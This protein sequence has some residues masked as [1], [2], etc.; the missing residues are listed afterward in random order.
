MYMAR[1]FL[2]SRTRLL[3]ALTR[4][5]HEDDESPAEDS[6]RSVGVISA[7]LSSMLF[8]DELFTQSK[9]C[10]FDRRGGRRLASNSCWVRPGEARDIRRRAA[11][12]KYTDGRD[13][14][15]DSKYTITYMY[16]LSRA[17]S[18]VVGR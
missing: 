10:L 12:Y 14:C 4:D 18:R 1:A 7:A 3:V 9:A 17:C 6:R 16:L 8:V 5:L 2:F 13:V 11:S 15:L